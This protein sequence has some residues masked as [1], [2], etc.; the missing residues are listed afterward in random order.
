MIMK[1]IIYSAITLACYCLLLLGTTA[2][3]GADL[4]EVNA[5]G[6]LQDKSGEEVKTDVVVTN[7]TPAKLGAEDN[8][9]AWWSVFT[10][11]IKAEPGKTYQVK[12]INYGGASNWNNFVV[13]LRKGDKSLGAEGEY[14]ILRADNWGWGNGW[15]GEELAQHCT[16]KMEEGRD[17]GTWL[18]AMNLAKCTVEITNKDNGRADV[19]CTM[20]GSDGV[21]YTQDYTDIVGIDKDDLYFSFTVDHSHIEFGDIDVKDTDPVSMVLHNVPAEINVGDDLNELMAGVTAD[22][23][24]KGVPSP[25][26]I[27]AED[28]QFSVLPD[29]ET[30]G[31]KTLV[32]VYNKTFLGKTATVPAVAMA[33]VQM[34]MN[35]KS[36]S[37]TKQ[38]TTTDYENVFSNGYPFNPNGMEVT[39]TFSN[40]ATAVL[41]NSQLKFS[42]VPGTVGTHNITVSTENGKT[43]TVQ[44]NV[45][46]VIQT[47]LIHPTPTTIGAEDNTTPFFGAQ[48][49]AFKAESGKT[50]QVNFTNYGGTL[51]FENFI[52][53][54]RKA[55]TTLG[56]AGEYGV[57]RSDNWGWGNGFA[58]E[59]LSQHCTASFEAGRDWGAWLKAMSNAKVYACISNNG[60]GKV[61]I[62][63][64]MLGKD[65]N[66]YKQDYLNFQ[67]NIDVNDLNVAF[68]LEKSHLVFE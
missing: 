47:S 2:C 23:T 4:Y 44:V 17:W 38:P 34:V 29:M 40:G 15:T 8:T 66:I 49:N 59:Q 25:K 31:E 28:L 16:P 65:G 1:K 51:N 55:D 48:T 7:P 60:D 27:K 62:R 37:I 50:Y 57:L 52:L 61:D 42:S 5:P 63:I 22:V 32:V 41:N 56:A 10:D 26:T 20:L 9:Q 21:T 45:K 39:A 19:K 35:V 3:E 11:D 54:L 13:I 24:F 18:A 46:S 33:K 14:A 30:A 64:V 53:V 36:I 43:A 68:T 67:N 6:W 58:A 12:F